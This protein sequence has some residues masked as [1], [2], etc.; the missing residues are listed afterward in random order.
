MAVSVVINK[1]NVGTANMSQN[2]FDEFHIWVK[3]ESA[4]ERE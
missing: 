1:G 4:I 2:A 3:L